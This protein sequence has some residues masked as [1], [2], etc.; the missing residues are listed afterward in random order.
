MTCAMNPLLPL[1]AFRISTM[2]AENWCSAPDLTLIGDVTKTLRFLKQIVVMFFS[3]CRRS[4]PRSS[5]RDESTEIIALIMRAV[6]DRRL[7]DARPGCRSPFG[8]VRNGNNSRVFGEN[9]FEG[10]FSVYTGEYLLSLFI[11]EGS[12]T[13]L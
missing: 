11:K 5:H 2:P 3:A 4:R 9:G 1:A 13:I 12:I 6:A 10:L 7:L 8:S